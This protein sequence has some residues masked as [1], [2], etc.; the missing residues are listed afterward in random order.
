VL[1]FAK[2]LQ[3]VGFADVGLG[4]YLGVARGDMWQE[5]YLAVA[6]LGFFYAGRLLERWA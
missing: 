2:V 1:L 4:L 6:G 5:L 3:A